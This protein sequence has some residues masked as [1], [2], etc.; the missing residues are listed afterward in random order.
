MGSIPTWAT[1]MN[2]TVYKVYGISKWVG[3]INKDIKDIR[4]YIGQEDTKE[5]A[6]FLAALWGLNMGVRSANGNWLNLTEVIPEI[7]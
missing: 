3:D 2:K 7:V 5:D 6:D 4:T 1:T